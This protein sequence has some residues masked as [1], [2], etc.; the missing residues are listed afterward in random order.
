MQRNKD[1]NRGRCLVGNRASQRQWSDVF[2]VLKRGSRHPEACPWKKCL[3]EV[4]AKWRLPKHTHA[5]S[6]LPADGTVRDV[7][8]SAADRRSAIRD[9]EWGLHTKSDF[10]K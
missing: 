1:S 6:S 2:T 3:S 8:E 5:Q 9:G 7:Q 10:Q 4:E